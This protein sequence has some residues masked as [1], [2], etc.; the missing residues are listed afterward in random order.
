VAR[1]SDVIHL[2]IVFP[3]SAEF[4]LL[5]VVTQEDAPTTLGRVT[6]VAIAVASQSR[7][8]F[9]CAELDSLAA[10]R[11]RPETFGE[12]LEKVGWALVHLSRGV[13]EVRLPSGLQNVN[14][15][16]AAGEAR[17]RGAQRD[18]SGRYL[19]KPDNKRKPTRPRKTVD[20]EGRLTEDPS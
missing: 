4:R 19:P 8:E 2:P 9:G 12:M 14:K 10:W 7:T 17:A 16:R 13:V 6:S 3:N 5:Q 1:K 20:A 15:R 18:G 11:P